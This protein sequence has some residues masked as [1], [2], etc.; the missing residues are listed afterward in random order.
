MKKTFRINLAGSIYNIDD[1]A[2]KMLDA[3]LVNLRKHFDSEADANETMHDFEMRISEL[4]SGRMRLG[5]EVITIEDVKMV[6]DQMGRPE[7]IFEDEENASVH[8][9]SRGP[10]NTTGQTN[11]V[12]INKKL[13]RNPDNKV[14]GGVCAGIASYFNVDATLIRVISFFL[15]LFYGVV[16][17]IYIILWIL[18]PE[19][20]TATERL[21][22]RGESVTVESIGKT[23]T[24]T[25]ETPYSSQDT[26][27]RPGKV[28]STIGL[29]LKVLMI[30]LA[31]LLSPFILLLLFVLFIVIIALF[32]GGKGVIEALLPFSIW[33]NLSAFS[34]LQVGG[35]TLGAL[36]MIG[37]PI[38]L[39]IYWIVGQF[40]H[41]KPM[42]SKL[43]WI[44]LIAWLV[45][46]V[47]SIIF[48][49]NFAHFHNMQHGIFQ[50][51]SQFG[52]EIRYFF[53]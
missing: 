7:D 52:N 16:F 2:Y 31:L 50:S 6:I 20:K 18:I 17:F 44:V 3:Y 13:F 28:M 40:T 39:V 41:L 25:L 8:G 30:G 4:F 49:V 36:L 23:V 38:A 12:P 9:N 22:M 32:A 53:I 21:Q 33:E 46:I 15:L 10:G 27:N 42:S 34:T 1:D 43:K 47:L 14:L 35:A 29:I 24:E 19:A 26:R 5:A 51:F 48:G 45:G 11:S 37:I